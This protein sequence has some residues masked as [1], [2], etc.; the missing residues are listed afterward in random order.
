MV[1]ATGIETAQSLFEIDYATYYKTENNF[2]VQSKNTLSLTDNRTGR[3]YE[4]PV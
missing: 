3:I 4:I 1:L 2:K